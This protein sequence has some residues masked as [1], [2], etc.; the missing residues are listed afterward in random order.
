MKQIKLIIL[1]IVFLSMYGVK[2]HAHDF[3][4]K[5]E[6]G[7]IIYYDLKSKFSDEVYVTYKG[8]ETRENGYKGDI[9]IPATVMYKGKQ[10]K[11]TRIDLGAF[12]NDYNLRSV[13]I[14][15]GI[16]FIDRAAFY[17]CC[18]MISVT[19]PNS[20]KNIDKGAFDKCDNL[21][22]VSVPK[23]C[24]IAST[25]FN[26]GKT[27]IT[28][29]ETSERP[30]LAD[31]QSVKESQ[32]QPQPKQQEAQ[33]QPMKTQPASNV[34]PD[35]D[36]NI[37]MTKQESQTTFAVIVGNETY[38]DEADVPFAQNDAKVFS[39]YCKKTLGISENHIRLVTNAGYNDLRKA[40]SWLRQ[41][42][43]AYSGEGRIIFYYAGHGI[44][45]EDAQS[46]YLLPVDGIGSDLGSAYP[47]DKLYQ[48]LSEMPSQSVTVFLDA[49]F[50]G[51][52]RDGG[53]MASTRGVAIKAKP[54]EAKGKM[55][56]FTAAQ[57]DETAY[58]FSRQQH[59]LFTYYLLK[60]LQESKGNV[61]LGDLADYLVTEVKRGSFEENRRLQTPTVN[62]SIA[63]SAS[64]RTM[65]LK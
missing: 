58:P 41:A 17:G 2:T 20:V 42:M 5:N 33:P 27:K 57:G 38:E 53:L 25:T 62:A 52:K 44:P 31:N 34:K 1:L 60:K 46:A 9:F 13:T 40:V 4:A 10:Y 55:V 36:L 28:R 6:Q 19:I 61:T 64:W 50:S 45:S 22:S 37:P 8:N 54:Q 65:K 23:D 12:W 47:L 59:G 56:V 49:C 43:E 7:Q 11:V 18:N 35:V 32:P 16:T 63:L 39:E 24:E 29:Y 21:V 15:E 14:S 51:S 26:D 3:S 30:M 48:T